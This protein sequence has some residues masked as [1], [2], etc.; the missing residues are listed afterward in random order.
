MLLDNSCVPQ[1]NSSN[2]IT[3]NVHE[4]E[5]VLSPS[6][7]SHLSTHLS[8]SHRPSYSQTAACQDGHLQS[9]VDDTSTARACAENSYLADSFSTYT[10]TRTILAL[11]F[12]T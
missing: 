4:A 7:S 5:I 11:T 2:H 10:Q 9:Y 12:F 8:T 6:H 1:W 3:D